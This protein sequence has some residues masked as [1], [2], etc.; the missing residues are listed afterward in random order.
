MADRMFQK[1]Q[2]EVEGDFGS[3]GGQNAPFLIF[4]WGASKKILY[5]I[6]LVFFP[7][8]LGP[9]LFCILHLCVVWFS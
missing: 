8:V 6:K 4:K 7:L 3:K 2:W 5:F 9:C 1:A